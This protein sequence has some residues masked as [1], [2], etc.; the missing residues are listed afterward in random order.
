MNFTILGAG[1]AGLSAAIKL[2]D[3]GHSVNVIEQTKSIGGFI[4]LDIQ[5]I[6]NYGR[7]EGILTKFRKEGIDFKHANKILKIVK[8]SPSYKSDII[9]SESEPLFYTF[10]RGTNKNSLE[11]QLADKVISMGG[12]ITLGQKGKISS[13]DIIA[14][15]SKFSP[16]GMIYGAVFENSNFDSNTVLQFLGSRFAGGYG[17]IAPYSKKLTTV[18]LTTFSKQSFGLLEKQFENFVKKEKL[19]VDLLKNASLVHKY[20]GHGH[21]NIPDTAVHKNKLFVGG[22]AGFVDP[23]RGF[24]IKYAILSGILAAKSINDGVNYDSLWKK[25]FEGE[26]FDGFGRQLLFQRLKDTDYENMVTGKMM[27]IKDYQKVPHGVKDIL[28]SINAKLS[29]SQHKAKFSFES[30]NDL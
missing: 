10:I 1:P 15:G 7:D 25:E 9:F 19:V 22:A 28:L 5:A 29:H 12:D 21:F 14:C 11:N 2:L 3:C 18:A 13:A 20:A 4:G 17:Y 23:A 16:E 6:R 8:L 30:I 24:G 27:N 26:L